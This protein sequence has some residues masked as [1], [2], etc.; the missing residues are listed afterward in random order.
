[1]SRVGCG[2][3]RRAAGEHHGEQDRGARAT[4]SDRRLRACLGVKW[5]AAQSV[6]G[7][8]LRPA[9]CTGGDQRVARVKTCGPPG[10]I[11][12]MGWRFR[13]S[14]SRRRRGAWRLICLGVGRQRRS[15]RAA[16]GCVTEAPGEGGV[17][18]RVHP[19]RPAEGGP[20]PASKGRLWLKWD[21]GSPTPCGC[22]GEE[23]GALGRPGGCPE[24]GPGS[25]SRCGSPGGAGS[26]PEGRA[27]EQK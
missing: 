11:R 12:G 5:D 7:S 13:P 18:R 3:D 21:V 22:H 15:R 16:L 17:G 2:E 25:R 23:A 1:M 8:C 19:A 26:P 10:A 6:S 9:C 24:A 20:C 4:G 27:A 14:T